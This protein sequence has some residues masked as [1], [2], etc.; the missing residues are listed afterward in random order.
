M[1]YKDVSSHLLKKANNFS[2]R[3]L[4][5]FSV[6][7]TVYFI[8]SILMYFLE[9]IRIG[10]FKSLTQSFILGSIMV[11]LLA[12]CFYFL[13]C[14]KAKNE[15]LIVRNAALS[16]IFGL[17]LYF[18]SA[19]VFL[20]EV[21]TYVSTA[22]WSGIEFVINDILGLVVSGLLLFSLTIFFS[23]LLVAMFAPSHPEANLYGDQPVTR[24]IVDYAQLV[25]VIIVLIFYWN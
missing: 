5:I 1:R 19:L 24:S 15:N 21:I 6:L 20:G 9:C 7:L 16:N 13:Q 2:M 12:G 23:S 18:F 17:G 3:L 25:I 14:L 22:N 8:S 10:M 4:G 11:G